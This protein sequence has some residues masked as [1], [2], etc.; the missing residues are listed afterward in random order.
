MTLIPFGT[1]LISFWFYTV[2]YGSIVAA[3]EKIRNIQV[4]VPIA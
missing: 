3:V 4:F 2:D 1:R